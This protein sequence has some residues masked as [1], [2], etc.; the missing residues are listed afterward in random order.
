MTTAKQLAQSM[1]SHEAIMRSLCFFSDPD[2]PQDP[3]RD[4][5]LA[6]KRCGEICGTMHPDPAEVD[7]GESEVIYDRAERETFEREPYVD[8]KIF[9]WD[10]SAI[11]MWPEFFG[12]LIESKRRFSRERMLEMIDKN[13]LSFI[14]VELGKDGSAT[15]IAATSIKTKGIELA[16]GVLGLE[17]EIELVFGKTSE[18]ESVWTTIFISG[19]GYIVAERAMSAL[20]YPEEGID[21][22]D[23]PAV[24]LTW[25]AA[26][27]RWD[28]YACGAWN[29]CCFLLGGDALL[30]D[31][32]ILE[33]EEID[34]L[35]REG[36][37]P[38]GLNYVGQWLPEGRMY[39]AY[40]SGY[41][42]ARFMSR[43]IGQAMYSIPE[44]E[45]H[46][47]VVKK[48]TY[49]PHGPRESHIQ[50]LYEEEYGMPLSEL[51]I[52]EI[53]I[54]GYKALFRDG[55]GELCEMRFYPPSGPGKTLRRPKIKTE[56]G[57]DSFWQQADDTDFPRGYQCWMEA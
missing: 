57:K 49:W 12:Q 18:F 31:F 21:L 15:P 28:R 56:K 43:F 47:A 40:M 10:Q 39:L 38:V 34:R 35:G 14:L 30:S 19:I 24:D 55:D 17:L 13:P 51:E 3:Y 6:H 48:I 42:F 27:K 44:S 1:F 5:V 26:D 23:V 45:I 7:F 25:S 54:C 46:S 50:V 32:E 2:D 53:S 52:E 41:G 33:K 29:A 36:P 37:V 9:H 4:S 20:T 22:S 8:R 16:E 11:E